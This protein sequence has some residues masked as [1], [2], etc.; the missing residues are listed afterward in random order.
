MC[1]QNQWRVK[2]ISITFFLLL[3]VLLNGVELPKSG[4][5]EQF[6]LIPSDLSTK[7][8]P[9]FAKELMVFPE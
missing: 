8:F 4:E 5:N 6:Y 1:S 9:E 7:E 2:S 3:S